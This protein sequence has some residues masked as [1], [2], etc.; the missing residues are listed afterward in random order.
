ML[1]KI[2]VLILFAVMIFAFSVTSFA[3]S[4]T[5]DLNQLNNENRLWAPERITYLLSSPDGIT[6]STGTVYEVSPRYA[7]D[8]QYLPQTTYV[9]VTGVNNNLDE[10]VPTWLR[11]LYHNTR[12]LYTVNPPST[13][14]GV[15]VEVEEYIQT[16]Y[17]SRRGNAQTNDVVYMQADFPRFFVDLSLYDQT[18]FVDNRISVSNIP[19]NRTFPFGVRVEYAVDNGVGVEFKTLEYS[20]YNTSNRYTFSLEDIISRIQ[21]KM[22]EN[23]DSFYFYGA[24]RILINKLSVSGYSTDGYCIVSQ[25]KNSGLEMVGNQNLSTD[26]VTPNFLNSM[27]SVIT[28]F[29][30]TTLF[31]VGS[32]EV[33]LGIVFA[34]PFVITILFVFLRKFAGG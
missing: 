21:S 12:Y 2:S 17:L 25:N 33:S 22:I 8:N 19:T 9:N 4:F 7:I 29:F 18:Q 24:N 34:L 23:G 5:G 3:Q 13:P 6:T 30:G 1:K 27:A 32:Y 11:Y 16:M 14:S 15:N 28:D 10:E 26:E 31:K 20:E